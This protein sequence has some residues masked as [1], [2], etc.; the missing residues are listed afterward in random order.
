M[1]AYELSQLIRQ[2][3]EDGTLDKN[4]HVWVGCQGYVN[5][6]DTENETDVFASTDGMNLLIV[7]SC[8]GYGQVVD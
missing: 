3:I 5:Y 8:G 2:S 1:I 7:D 6:G 4:A